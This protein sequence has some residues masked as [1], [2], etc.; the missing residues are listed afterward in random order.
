VEPQE[1]LPAAETVEIPVATFASL[2]IE[3]QTAADSPKASRVLVERDP[4]VHL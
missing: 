2:D 1:L 3:A 4:P